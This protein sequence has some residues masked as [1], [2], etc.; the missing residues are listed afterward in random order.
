MLIKTP[1][2]ES[3]HQ[4]GYMFAVSLGLDLTLLLRPLAHHGLDHVMT[5]LGALETKYK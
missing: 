1:D 4:L 2:L 5:H 3:R